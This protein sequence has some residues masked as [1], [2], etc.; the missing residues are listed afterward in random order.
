MQKPVIKERSGDEIYT[1]YETVE[2]LIEIYDHIFQLYDCIWLPFNSNGRPI[3]QCFVNKYGR[4][5]IKTTPQT[6]FNPE[7]GICDFWRWKDDPD[8][9]EIIRS[10]KT[11][12]FDNP[13]FS[14]LTRII[15]E[16]N[17]YNMDWI[18]FGNTQSGLDRYNSVHC[19][20]HILGAVP[21]DNVEEDKKISISL[22][23]N[24]FKEIKYVFGIGTDNRDSG[25]LTEWSDRCNLQKYRDRGGLVGSSEIINICARGFVFDL[26]KIQP[27]RAPH[28]FGGSIIYNGL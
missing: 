7:T 25:N 21:F 11:L 26:N 4:D 22:F 27:G 24:L 23:S 12:I 17:S 8:F 10:E 13:P 3:E 19:G 9:Y 15:K 1:K 14:A 20:Y 16:L 28:K 6:C 18:L 5:K 2:K